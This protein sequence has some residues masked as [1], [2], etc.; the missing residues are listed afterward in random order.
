M[1]DQ[2]RPNRAIVLLHAKCQ[3]TGITGRGFG[4]GSEHQSARKE[5]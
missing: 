3:G 5:Q 1:A 4:H 2:L